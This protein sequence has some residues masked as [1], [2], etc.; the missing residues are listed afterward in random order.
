MK[1]PIASFF[2]TTLLVIGAS[3]FANPEFLQEDLT[4]ISTMDDNE[5]E[6]DKIRKQIK[7][8]EEVWNNGDYNKLP[9]FFT[10]DAHVIF[11]NEIERNGRAEIRKA[12]K[13][14]VEFQLPEGVK[15]EI[16]VDILDIRLLTDDVAVAQYAYRVTGLPVAPTMELT[17]RSTVTMVR[18]GDRWL[19]SHQTNWAPTNVDC[20]RLCRE[21]ASGSMGQEQ[22]NKEIVRKAFE[23]VGAGDYDRMGDYIADYYIRHCQAT[24]QVQVRSLAAFKEFIR[25]DRA[26]IPDQQLEVRYLVAEDDKVAFWATYKGTQTG[27]MGPFP[28]SGKYAELDFAG[29]HRLEDGKIVESW[30]TWDNVTILSQLGHF[31]AQGME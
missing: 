10:E 2:L 9:E 12:F 27:Q 4:T 15:R 7:A 18:T 8:W 20:V 19:W 30:V 28:P 24:P 5:N 25:Q 26:A 17:G 14:A 11:P 3:A 13:E 21:A 16:S 1:D 31:P 29:V 6:K 23:V 22:R